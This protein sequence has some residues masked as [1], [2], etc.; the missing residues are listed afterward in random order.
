MSKIKFTLTIKP[1]EDLKLKSEKESYNS[2]LIKTETVIEEK[3]TNSNTNS[4]D[5]NTIEYH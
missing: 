4:Q 5:K 3:T 1:G 2:E